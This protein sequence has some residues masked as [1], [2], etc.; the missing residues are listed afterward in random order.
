MKK[1]QNK[2]YLIGAGGYGKQLSIMLKNN[3]IIKSAI[4][5]DDKLKLNIKEFL[6]LKNKNNFSI[7]IGKPKV[8]EK[9]FNLLKKKN[10]IIQH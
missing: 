8:R 5:V 3:E 1:A 9:I 10:Y 7:C 4:F 6:K 2:F